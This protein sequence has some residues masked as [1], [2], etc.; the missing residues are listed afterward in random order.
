MEHF[1]HLKK[2]NEVKQCFKRFDLDGNGYIDKQELAALSLKLGHA[3]DE[4]QLN[5][6]LHDLD[7]NHDGTIDFEEFCRWYFTGMKPYTGAKR[8]MLQV[9]MKTTTLFEALKKESIAA[10]LTD[11]RLTK[12]RMSVKFNS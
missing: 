5:D 12:H 9:G 11:Q 1:Y 10:I 4:K 2:D 8:S 6:A 3:L 7:L